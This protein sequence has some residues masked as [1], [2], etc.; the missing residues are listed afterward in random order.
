MSLRKIALNLDKFHRDTQITFQWIPS[1]IG[2]KGNDTPDAIA[3]SAEIPN[4]DLDFN[5]FKRT[6]K[7]NIQT[8]IQETRSHHWYLTQKPGAVVECGMNRQA[9]TYISRLKTD[10][11]R[12]LLFQDVVKTFR[13]CTIF[14]TKEA[15]PDHLLECLG[16]SIQDLY[17]NP[18]KITNIYLCF[19]EYSKSFD[20]VY[21]TE[22]W[23]E[24]KRMGIP[25]HLIV[26]IKEL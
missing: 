1:Y 8:K 26:L 19:I 15:S 7:R 25:E 18:T 10:H 11:T 22:L 21:H 16:A 3:K 12:A 13:Q 6:Q 17:S 20:C 14:R 9:A 24:L 5:L 4:L 23:T 2:L